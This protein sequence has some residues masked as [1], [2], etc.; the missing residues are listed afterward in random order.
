MTIASNATPVAASQMYVEA[1][2][3]P[4]AVAAQLMRDEAAYREFGATLRS[5]NP[6][7]VSRERARAAWWAKRGAR[8]GG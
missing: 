2:E 3:A 5:A 1:R 6:T 7:A 4:A 8:K